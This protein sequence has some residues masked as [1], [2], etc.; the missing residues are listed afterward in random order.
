ALP[1]PE[2]ARPDLAG[3]FT[4]P[5]TP[6]EEIIA[7]IWA[8][9]LGLDRVGTTDNF[10]ELGGHSLVGIQV[11]SQIRTAFERDLPLAALFDHPTVA[12]LAALIDTMAPGVAIPE[13]VPVDRDRALPLSFAQQRL[14]FLD[15]LQSGSAQYNVPF[16]LRFPGR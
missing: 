7:D 16:A 5:G 3:A 8:G 9:M 12:A 11:I 13:I 6:T 14:W 4:P 10:F 15:Q 1:A 2:G